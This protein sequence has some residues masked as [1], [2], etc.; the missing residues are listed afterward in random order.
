MIGT[1]SFRFDQ[2]EMLWLLLLSIPVVWLG[3]RGRT[4][5]KLSQRWLAIVLRLLVLT[6]LVLILAEV[7]W[8]RWHRDLTV[9]AVIDQSQSVR[10]FAR[11]S[12]IEHGDHST[13][14]DSAYAIDAWI[15]QWMRHATVGRGA[16]DRLGIVTFDGQPT[17]RQLP[18]IEG[19]VDTATVVEP[20]AGTDTAAAIRLAMALFA[21]DS[22]KRIVLISDGNDAMGED[23]LVAAR[24]AQAASIPIDVLPLEYR[25]D[26]EVMVESLHAPSEA[27]LE[28]TVALRIV[29]RATQPTNGQLY[30]RHNGQWIDF[31]SDLQ[32]KTSYSIRADQWAGAELSNDQSDL[33]S[34]RQFDQSSFNASYLWVHRL[35]L[36]LLRSGPNRF[37]VVFEPTTKHGDTVTIN[38]RA[39]ATTLVHGKLRILWI[40]QSDAEAEQ[41]LPDVLRDRGIDIERC[42]SYAIPSRLAELQDFDAVILSNI[43][44]EQVTLLQQ[45]LLATY[46]NDL[47]GGVIMIGGVDAFG[48]GAWTDTRID[49]ILP[50]ECRV[51]NE[52]AL[53]S[54]ALVLVLDQSGSMGT[55]VFGSPYTKQRIANEAAVL[56]I[57]TLDE[58]DMVAVI[59]F[60]SN[61]RW[62]IPLQRH[63]DLSVVTDQ[64]RKIAPGG[65]TNIY[66]ALELACSTLVELDAQAAAVKHVVL[67][68]DG[69]GK[70]ARYDKL[71][72]KLIDGG[73]TLS[74]IGVGDDVNGQLLEGLA[75]ATGGTYYA[76]AQPDQL[77]QVFIKEARTIRKNLIQE[78][79]FQPRLVQSGS[80]ITVGLDNPPSL[81]GFVLTGLKRNGCAYT[82]ILGPKGEPIFAHWQVGLGRTAAFT[83][84]A[85]VRWAKHWLQWPGFADFWVRVVRSIARPLVH[86]QWDLLVWIEGDRLKIRLDTALGDSTELGTVRHL[87]I[88]YRME[89]RVLGPDDTVTAVSLQQ[90]SPG[91][92]EAQSKATIAGDYTVSV[93]VKDSRSSD[94]MSVRP[95]RLVGAVSRSV[96]EELRILRSNRGV[97]EQVAQLTGGRVLK[98]KQPV[99]LFD[100]DAISPWRSIRPVWQLMI[101]SLLLVFLL[102]VAARRMAWD[103]GGIRGWIRE[104]V[105]R[106]GWT[107]SR[108]DSPV[109]ALLAA[110]KRRV[111]QGDES[112]NKAIK[113]G[114]RPNQRV[115]VTVASAPDQ[116]P[117]DLTSA[118]IDSTQSNSTIADRI[119]KATLD[120][121]KT[122]TTRRLLDAKRRAAGVPES[123]DKE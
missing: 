56:A 89:G 37:E 18:S 72:S 70:G 42:A 90:T 93:L 44:A 80:S 47:G 79:S 65:G 29:L 99:G 63:R 39:R 82:P 46:V 77:P 9:V 41:I 119:D 112:W 64:V 68:T 73:I 38:N 10:Q 34:N 54:G 32:Q 51:P 66:A 118:R 58:Q 108:S 48:A 106:L 17:V 84:D 113:S 98:P 87:P 52:A 20:V 94:A 59:G 35:E 83:S 13:A 15:A 71:I 50:V 43:P 4:S 24:E 31:N 69:R 95:T 19:P 27:R 75:Q 3:V 23:L 92:Y 86:R 6:I 81:E 76:V 55:E 14:T 116:Q 12:T 8:V 122:A 1:V 7:E 103:V 88:S 53:P 102:D 78:R 33:L 96:G 123:F 36:P 111:M 5:L 115:S 30:L 26:H 62:I 97:L 2:S 49:R 114:D 67:L 85:T 101:M 61:P 109:V 117:S 45:E 22:S 105:Q 74:T 40:D 11:P 107:R 91:I 121:K 120:G 25:I 21:A 110:H 57:N 104:R 28:Q 100:R 16:D 60:D